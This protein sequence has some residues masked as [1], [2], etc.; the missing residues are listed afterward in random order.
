M[1][2][3]ATGQSARCRESAGTEIRELARI[4]TEARDLSRAGR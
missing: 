1:I 2:L 4:A 3:L